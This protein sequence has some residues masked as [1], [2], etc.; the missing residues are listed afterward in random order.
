MYWGRDVEKLGA[1]SD[2]KESDSGDC[3]WGR[4]RHWD[5]RRP[6][7]V[8]TNADVKSTLASAYFADTSLEFGCWVKI[9][10]AFTLQSTFSTWA[11]ERSK[12]GQQPL[13]PLWTLL[14][15]NLKGQSFKW[16]EFW[17]LHLCK[18]KMSFWLKGASLS[19]SQA[20]SL[21]W[22]KNVFHPSQTPPI[23]IIITTVS[24]IQSIFFCLT[25]WTDFPPFPPNFGSSPLF[26]S[27]PSC[28]AARL[29]WRHIPRVLL[30]IPQLKPAQPTRRVAHCCSKQKHLE[31][32]RRK[33]F[34]TTLPS[35]K[36]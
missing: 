26:G 18:N 21:F 5:R 14:R 11:W 30:V 10:A 12:W 33:D 17:I 36:T 24:W 22:G 16:E 20:L 3:N 32:K 34:W 35:L 2:R 9:V 1:E 7:E 28:P 4:I 13:H 31:I 19:L 25:C 15:L 6:R 29:W 23:F 8:S 27:S